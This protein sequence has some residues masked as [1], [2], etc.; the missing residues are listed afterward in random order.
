MTFT[1]YLKDRLLVLAGWGVLSLLLVFMVWLTPD[2][3]GF[4]DNLG[5]LLTLQLFLVFLFFTLDFYR[6][7]KWYKTFAKEENAHLQHFEMSERNGWICQ[8]LY[9][10]FQKLNR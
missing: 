7:K 9:K 2:L 8:N 5:Y 4:W 6:R 10:Y 3:H 1:K